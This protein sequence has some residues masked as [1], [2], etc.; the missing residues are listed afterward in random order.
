MLQ[1]RI[2]VHAEHLIIRE[3]G[4]IIVPARYFVDII[5]NS[6]QEGRVTLALSGDGVISIKSGN[7]VYRLCGMP[8]DEF[9][10]MEPIQQPDVT[11]L[12]NDR[13]KALIGQVAFAASASEMRPI[14]TGVRCQFSGEELRLMATDGI[15][16]A[17]QAMAAGA[18]I[19]PDRSTVIVPGK[20]LLHYAK[21][22]SD[23][24]GTTDIS[25]QPN[26]IML[27]SMN[28]ILQSSLIEGTYPLSVDQLRPQISSTV[29]TVDRDS[30]LHA[31]ERVTL[32]AGERNL[33]RLHA[34]SGTMMLQLHSQTAEIGD[35]IEELSIEKLDGEGLTICF[36][37]TYMRDIV[38][39]ADCITVQL[40]FT[41]PLKPIMIQPLGDPV[42]LYMLTPIRAQFQHYLGS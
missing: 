19:L 13:L 14:L 20:N 12:S 36:N 23:E 42:A 18:E 30:L 4:R 33:V 9:P 11:G 39:A 38:Q 31:L 22:L 2:P 21:L 17:S 37:G 3:E 8:A 27:R 28:L 34:A 1:Y 32:L 25:I 26:K 10:Q 40:S 7:A 29:I 15:R 24:G 41:G 16:L 6:A 35:V 5:R